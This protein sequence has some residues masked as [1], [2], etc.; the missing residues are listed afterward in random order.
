M[1]SFERIFN[2][3]QTI[4]PPA[5]DEKKTKKNKNTLFESRNGTKYMLFY[6]T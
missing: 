6:I 1:V 3:I 5:P 4:E 2:A